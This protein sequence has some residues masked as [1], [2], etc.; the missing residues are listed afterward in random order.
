MYTRSGLRGA[1]RVTDMLARR[2]P[3]LHAVPVETDS[4]V[5]FIDLRIASARTILAYPN[6]RSGEDTVMKHFVRPGDTVFDIG[7]HLG[8]YTLLLSRL[9]G[10]TGKVYAFEPNPE[11]LPSLKRTIEPHDNVHL[12]P[13]A[14]SDK[15]GQIDLFVPDDA[16]MASLSDWTNG[17]AGD[18]HTVKTQMRSMDALVAEEKLP[19]PDFIKCDVEGAELLAFMGGR[20][21]LDREAAPVILFELNKPAAEAFGSTPADYLEFLEQLEAPDYSFFEVTPEGIKSLEAKEI[22]YANLLAVPRSKIDFA[23][24]FVD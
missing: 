20:K 1:Y 24:E 16:S 6:S 7:A 9:A 21:T 18:V 5:I 19:L 11:L 22:D 4:G 3:S 13:I 10:A 8:F 14:L 17:I 12:F 23:R 2:M 15:D